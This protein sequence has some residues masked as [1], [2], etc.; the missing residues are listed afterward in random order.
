MNAHWWAIIASANGNSDFNYSLMN[1]E[2]NALVRQKPSPCVR[3]TVYK[4]Y[5]RR[6]LRSEP[7]IRPSVCAAPSKATFTHGICRNICSIICN[8]VNVVYARGARACKQTRMQAMHAGCVTP[9]PQAHGHV[10]RHSVKRPRAS[11]YSALAAA[12]AAAACCWLL[13]LPRSKKQ[14]A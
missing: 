3:S 7:F 9:K 8:Y 13:L 4:I 1:L 10:D 11:R 2:R 5:A 14:F 6:E 12:T